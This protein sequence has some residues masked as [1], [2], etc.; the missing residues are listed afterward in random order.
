MQEASQDFANA[1]EALST[2]QLALLGASGGGSRVVQ[3]FLEGSGT[4]KA[5]RRMIKKL[6]GSF[7]ALALTPGGSFLT[8]SCFG[9]AVSSAVHCLCAAQYLSACCPCATVVREGWTC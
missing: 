7:G 2:A 1:L 9:A 4:S 8:E 5:K 6:T 3:A